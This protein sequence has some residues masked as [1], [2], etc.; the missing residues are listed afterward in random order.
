MVYYLIAYIQ[1]ALYLKMTLW[2]SNVLFDS[3]R[4]V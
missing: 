2:L 1:E 3:K 4:S